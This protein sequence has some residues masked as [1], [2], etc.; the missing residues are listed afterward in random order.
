MVSSK[1]YPDLERA[2]GKMDNWIEREGGLPEYIERIAKHLHYEE[3]M[4]ISHAIAAAV[5]TVKRWARKG[6]VVKYG[7]PKNKNVTTI[8]AAQAAKA[9]AE[10]EAKKAS[11]K[12]RS[13]GRISSKSINLAE[14]NVD[15]NQLVERANA[16]E[17]PVSRGK[18]RQAIVDLAFP[19]GGPPAFTRK[20]EAAKGNALPDGSFPIDDVAQL[21]K[22]VLAFGRAKDK[23]AAKR[24][25]IKRAKELNATGSLPKDWN[26]TDL[27]ETIDLAGVTKDGRKSYKKQGKW[28]HG[29]IPVDDK[30]KQSKAKGSP[31][32]RK[33]M[34]RLYGSTGAQNKASKQAT[35][36]T[37]KLRA[38]GGGKDSGSTETV[39][40]LG[41]LRN[42][43]VRDSTRTQRATNKVG[44]AEAGKKGRFNATAMKS[45]SEIPDEAKITRNGKRYVV[46]N[47]NGRKLL[48]EW[49][50]PD[51]GREQTNYDKDTQYSSIESRLAKNKSTAELGRITKNMKQA[52]NVRSKARKVLDKKRKEGKKG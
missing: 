5:N 3:G 50:G 11:A 38:L 17:D 40:R 15:L 43:D 47:Q 30:A 19:A 9:V 39:S 23:A 33:R 20:K 14:G 8:T 12:A 16:I 44:Q 18:A 28:K 48:T 46:A 4:T 31:V 6:K 10:W 35:D 41:A 27:S 52:K 22:A 36:R 34:N 7:D 32:A 2:P 1:A 29:F 25:I 49:V 24:H 13:G 51:G 21:R 26:V 37:L 42:A 45:W